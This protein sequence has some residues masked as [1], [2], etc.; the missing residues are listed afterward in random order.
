MKVPTLMPILTGMSLALAAAAT[1]S[2]HETS[3]FYLEQALVH[4]VTPANKTHEFPV[5]MVPG[6]NLSSS[7]YLTT[8]DGRDGWAQQFADAGYE[9]YAINDPRFDFSRGFSVP[10]FED[11]P[12]LGAPPADP[13]A[14]QGWQQDIWRRW[15][16]GDSEGKPYPDSQ[17]PSDHFDDFEENYPYLSSSTS[18]F[19]EAIAALLKQTGPAILMAHSAG[20]PQALSAAYAHPELIA[21]LVL[22]EPT[23]PPTA[24]DFP[25]LAGLAMLGV[26]AD[27][28]DSRGQSSRKEGTEAAAQLFAA[29]GGVGEAISLPEDH[30]VKGNSHLMMQDRNNASISDLIITWLNEHAKQP[31]T[32]PGKGG[33]RPGGVKGGMKGGAKGGKGKGARMRQAQEEE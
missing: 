33:V 2:A 11:V 18:S 26:Y 4:R 5:I 29:N 30:G 19:S 20:G 12:S 10:G 1:V 3:S 24:S 21:G 9:V 28:I 23:G 25:T 15:G 7:I 31:K 27:Y 14:Q 13:V 22:V 32:G 8:P 6:L 17:F 16:F